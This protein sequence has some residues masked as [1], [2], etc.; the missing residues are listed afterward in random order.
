MRDLAVALSEECFLVRA[1]LLPGHGTRPGDLLA[2]TREDW[3]ESARFGIS[4]LAGDVS[5]IYVAGVSLGG[6]IA[7]EI[8]LTDPRIRGIIALSP[9]FSIERA[10]WVG[11]SVWLRHLVTWA[12]TEASED[13]ARYEA[14]PFNALAETFLLSHDLQAMLRTRGYVETPL[15]LAQS[16]DDGTIDIFENLRIF[17]HHFRS[18]LSRLLIYERA[19][20]S[21]TMPDEPRVLRLDSLHP[22]QRIY[23]YSH[24]ALHVSPRNPHYGRNGDYRDC[25]ATADRPPDAVER[26]LS[27]PQPLRGET[28]ARAEIPGIDMQAMARL[29]FNPNFARLVERILAF[30]NAVSAS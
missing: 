6:L 2:V 19:P 24:L 10:A 30:A 28:F 23:G 20:D 22:E 26:C 9:A 14:M 27:A 5:E 18:P 16:A 25:G 15:F 12:D 7:A 4:T 17:R 1:I 3:L 8:G 11:Q 21:P 29:T 13:Y